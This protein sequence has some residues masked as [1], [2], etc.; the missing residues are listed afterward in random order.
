MPIKII[1]VKDLKLGR[2]CGKEAGEAALGSDMF[3]VTSLSSEAYLCVLCLV[4]HLSIRCVSGDMQCCV[5][6]CVFREHS[7]CAFCL[8]GM[9]RDL[10][11][12]EPGNE[13]K[14]P[15]PGGV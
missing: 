11:A 9:Q 12:G 1:I 7:S 10:G 2:T 3:C 4:L 14:G 13:V 5:K 15:L 6:G 8:W